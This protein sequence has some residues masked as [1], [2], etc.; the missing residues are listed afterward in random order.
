MYSHRKRT[1]RLKETILQLSNLHYLSYIL[2]QNIK[3][4]FQTCLHMQPQININIYVIISA[5]DSL[6]AFTRIKIQYFR[7][8]PKN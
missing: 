7:K 1:K 2:I 3:L 5:C 8:E 6:P 4:I